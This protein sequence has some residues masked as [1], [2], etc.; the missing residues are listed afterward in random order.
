MVQNAERSRKLGRK[1]CDSIQRRGH[2]LVP[3]MKARS[4]RSKTFNPADRGEKGEFLQM[5]TLGGGFA[6][7]KGRL[8]PSTEKSKFF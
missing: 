2:S 6:N 7:R 5:L 4:H 8:L 3:C 1:V